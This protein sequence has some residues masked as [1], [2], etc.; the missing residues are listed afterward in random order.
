MNVAGTLSVL[1]LY[2]GPV[3]FFIPA[4]IHPA[5]PLIHKNRERIGQV[6]KGAQEVRNLM[7]RETDA[8]MPAFSKLCLIFHKSACPAVAPHEPDIKIFDIQ[9]MPFS[10]KG[11]SRNQ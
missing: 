10:A 2:I 4:D 7:D 11:A 9:G 6:H 5:V 1:Y 3:V 8:L